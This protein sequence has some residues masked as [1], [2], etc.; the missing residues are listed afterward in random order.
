MG[1][2]EKNPA[3]VP[4]SRVFFQQAGSVDLYYKYPFVEVK[5]VPYSK[6][7][8]RQCA[9]SATQSWASVCAICRLASSFPTAF[10][11]PSISRPMPIWGQ[12]SRGAGKH[13]K[14]IPIAR[15]DSNSR[16]PGHYSEALPALTTIL[17]RAM[18]WFFFYFYWYFRYWRYKI[19]VILNA[20]M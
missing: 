12:G 20:E 13:P 14:K 15:R 6:S 8:R 19:Q 1:I 7:V 5:G 2:Y 10:H 3:L 16:L 9:D 17:S 18:T 4:F 11:L